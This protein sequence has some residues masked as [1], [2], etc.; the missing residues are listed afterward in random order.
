MS[1]L[2]KARELRRTLVLRTSTNLRPR[3]SH[4]P[5]PC[6]NAQRCTQL[7]KRQVLAACVL[8]SGAIIGE[9]RAW[10]GCTLSREAQQF[11]CASRRPPPPPP[12]PRCMYCVVWHAEPEHKKHDLRSSGANRSMTLT[13]TGMCGSLNSLPQT[14][15]CRL[16]KFCTQDSDGV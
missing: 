9:F 14:E 16:D 8:S 15:G 3:P 2:G 5:R 4:T 1:S 7:G 12:S 6:S 11:V 13:L 10:G